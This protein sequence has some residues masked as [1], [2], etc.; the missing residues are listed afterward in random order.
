MARGRSNL[1][2]SRRGA[3]AVVFPFDPVHRSRLAAAFPFGGRLGGCRSRVGA[4]LLHHLPSAFSKR[5]STRHTQW[6]ICH[7]HFLLFYFRAFRFPPLCPVPSIHTCTYGPQG[8]VSHHPDL[9]RI[10]FFFSVRTTGGGDGR[11]LT[12]SGS[13][14]VPKADCKSQQLGFRLTRQTHLPS[15]QAGCGQGPEASQVNKGTWRMESEK[16]IGRG[17]RS[18]AV[19]L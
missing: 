11:Q 2:Q 10:F 18:L 1:I 5:R 17:C 19:S 15:G 8:P 3:L 4:C 6:A 14:L 7:F 12:T 9:S 16:K 13:Q